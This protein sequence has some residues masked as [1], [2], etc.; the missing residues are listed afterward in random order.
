MQDDKPLPRE[1]AIGIFLS[2]C[3]WVQLCTLA[4][5]AAVVMALFQPQIAAVCEA[6]G[7]GADAR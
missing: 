5:Q 3:E 1:L 7:F 4:R 6:L 2:I